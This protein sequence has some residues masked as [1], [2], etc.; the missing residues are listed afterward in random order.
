MNMRDRGLAEF[1]AENANREKDAGPVPSRLTVTCDEEHIDLSRYLDRD[2]LEEIDIR[3]CY[4]AKSIDF[5][6]LEGNQTLRIIRIIGNGP[7]EELIFPSTCPN[8]EE[9]IIRGSSPVLEV[10]PEVDPALVQKLREQ[11]YPYRN[12][13]IGELATRPTLDERRKYWKELELPEPK[14]PVVSSPPPLDLSGLDGCP[15]LRVIK[16]TNN[17]FGESGVILPSRCPNL[18]AVLLNETRVKEW[19]LDDSPKIRLVKLEVPDYK[20]GPI[21]L[22]PL[23][24]HFKSPR[25]PPIISLKSNTEL[26]PEQLI[27]GY[28]KFPKRVKDRTII[29]CTPHYRGHIYIPPFSYTSKIWNE[30]LF[31]L[32]VY[33]IASRPHGWQQDKK[34]QNIPFRPGLYKDY[35]E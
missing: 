30:Y 3:A 34:W 33:G 4:N 2:S 27:K 25:K 31:L 8:L 13:G 24:A 21:D 6:A 23:L 5:R 28:D 7:I 12:W 19:R 10:L 35:G 15:R 9:L 1:L 11:Y 16:I 32:G 20:H 17:H 29:M 18:E 22:A 14:E 26:D